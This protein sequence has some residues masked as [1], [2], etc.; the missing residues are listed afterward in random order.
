ML[1]VISVLVML[2]YN[3]IEDTL[4]LSYWM[5]NIKLNTDSTVCLG[6]QASND[7]TFTSANL[8]RR[9]FIHAWAQIFVVTQISWMHG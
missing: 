9:T 5:S 8:N 3:F 4:I 2:R 1:S 6:L 7:V